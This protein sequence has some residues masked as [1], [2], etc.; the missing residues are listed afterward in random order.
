MLSGRRSSPSWRGSRQGDS[1]IMETRIRRRLAVAGLQA[2]TLKKALNKALSFWCTE[3]RLKRRFF[4]ARLC[5]PPQRA[6]GACACARH[7]AA[8]GTDTAK[9]GS[10]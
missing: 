4:G 10:T 1:D 9:Y 7:R 5:G 3:R 8:A 6:M 2:E